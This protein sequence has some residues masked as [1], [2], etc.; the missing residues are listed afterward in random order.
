MVVSPL[1]IVIDPAGI[2]AIVNCGNT[3]STVVTTLSHPLAA[4]KVSA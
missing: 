3:V 4:V 1:H 2:I